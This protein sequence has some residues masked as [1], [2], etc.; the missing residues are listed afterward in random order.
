M[1]A[2]ALGTI[3]HIGWCYLFTVK[4]QLGV[5]GL[6]YATT[7]TYFTMVLMITINTSLIHSIRECVFFPTLESFRDWG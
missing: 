6:G 2:Q 7:I 5:E 3:I 1:L 4:L